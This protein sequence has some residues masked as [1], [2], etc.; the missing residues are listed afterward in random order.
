MMFLDAFEDVKTANGTCSG[1]NIKYQP[2]KNQRLFLSISACPEIEML[3]LLY[4]SSVPSTLL[5]I[6]GPPTRKRMCST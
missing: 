3:Q 6:V 1:I 5:L 2:K 4:V